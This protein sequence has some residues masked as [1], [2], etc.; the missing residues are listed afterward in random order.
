MNNPRIYPISPKAQIFPRT[1]EISE[2]RL[3]FINE[4]ES[5]NL[6]TIKTIEHIFA[7]E[8][9]FLYYPNLNTMGFSC[10]NMKLSTVQQDL[11]LSRPVI[12]L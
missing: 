5:Q 3:S 10:D 9:A 7:E 8:L 6:P 12:G 2:N 4:T 1:K 11:L